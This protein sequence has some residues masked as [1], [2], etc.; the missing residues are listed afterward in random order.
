METEHIHILPK[1]HL[2]HGK[3]QLVKIQP[4]NMRSKK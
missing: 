3:I 2:I 4:K 1:D